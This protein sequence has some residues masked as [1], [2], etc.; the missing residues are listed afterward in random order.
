[1]AE[2]ECCVPLLKCAEGQTAFGERR[3]GGGEEC[4][5]VDSADLAQGVG[6]FRLSGVDLRTT[7][8][9]GVRTVEGDHRLEQFINSDA[10]GWALALLVVALAL[11]GGVREG[12]RAVAAFVSTWAVVVPVACAGALLGAF[13]GTVASPGWSPWWFWGASTVGLSSGALAMFVWGRRVLALMRVRLWRVVFVQVLVA[14]FSVALIAARSQDTV[15]A[16]ELISH[17][18]ALVG[19]SHLA[20]R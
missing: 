16:Q 14:L 20:A 13:L 11:L 2:L 6:V 5:C 12:L 3:F 17:A 15:R 1:M 18:P 8:R 9:A 7:Y 10:A 4:F 19:G